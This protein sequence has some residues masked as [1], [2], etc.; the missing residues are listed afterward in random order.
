MR[1]IKILLSLIAIIIAI[2]IAAP[3]FLEPNDFKDQISSVVE[4]ATG[5]KLQIQG[6]LDIS[7]FPWLGLKTG[8]L[9]L[10]NRSG[11]EG[12]S[13]ATIDSAQ[14]RVKLV[15]LLSN[16]I[17][18][19][20][21]QLNGLNLNLQQL[22]NGKNNWSDLTAK[23]GKNNHEKTTTGTAPKIAA[24][25]IGG[26]T[27][28][29]ATI[30]FRDA[31]TKQ[32]LKLTQL[33]LQT[34]PLELGAAV[35]ISLATQLSAQQP[36]LQ[37]SVEII[38]EFK[39]NP[40][41]GTYQLNNSRITTNLKGKTLPA[42]ELKGTLKATIA[43]NLIKQ[44]LQLSKLNLSSDPLNISGDMNVSKIFSS[45]P[46]ISGLL[47]VAAFNPKDLF[48]KLK[49]DI[50]A[51]AD[52]KAMTRASF[53]TNISGSLQKINL[54]KLKL[55]L[56]DSLIQGTFSLITKKHPSVTYNL[57]LDQ[58]DL[59]R[60]LPPAA[61]QV[62]RFSLIPVAIAATTPAPLFPVDLL[63][64]FDMAGDIN[65]AQLIMNRLK[66]ENIAIKLNQQ[67][68]FLK[69]EPIKGLAYNGNYL[70]HIRIDARKQHGNTPVI[71]ANEQLSNVNIGPVI[72]TITGKDAL[73][74]KG[75]VSAVL[76]T[77]GQS[78]RALKQTLN[79]E[80]KISLADGVLKGID[81][82]NVIKDTYAKYKNQRATTSTG[83]GTGK[84]ET[85]FTN[86]KVS[87]QVRNG[88]MNSNDLIID[89][90]LPRV[91]GKGT[92]NL[93]NNTI[94]YTL[95]TS[96]DKSIVELVGMRK[97]LVGVPLR[98]NLNGNLASPSYNVDW[99]RTIGRVLEKTQKKK[100]LDSLF[101]KK[102]KKSSTTAPATTQ[103]APAKTETAAERKKR[104]KREKKEKIKNL[105][106]GLF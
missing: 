78:I 74:G 27:I 34:G 51:M 76:T 61:T 57:S 11:F 9:N 42:G 84:Q 39:A 16:K 72:Q 50:P 99:L 35:D 65:A 71:S 36:K 95:R 73:T 33:N 20:S 14:I 77:R 10:G 83:T 66:I 7:I 53:N 52:D 100:L 48:K 8:K 22:K 2:A 40:F 31:N 56:D 13:F 19:D 85:P 101:G 29:D 91:K 87:F 68:G 55:I 81:I 17:E 26:I 106:K 82:V 67:R 6:D 62:S 60:Y 104:K 3:F 43:A 59:D 44:T 63:R 97:E 1:F 90:A 32:D 96:L 45:N 46:A 12:K 4:D 64:S 5:R 70:G 98:I 103:T 23:S 69:I 15:P 25:A 47:D 105:L 88:I 92:I 24:I 75:N 94:D 93:N 102:K 38:T 80:I 58:I 54:S 37:G 86:M 49:I 79:G 89:S 28:K 21:L 18:M 41:D 30:R